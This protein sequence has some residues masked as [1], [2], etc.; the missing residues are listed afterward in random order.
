MLQVVRASK[1]TCTAP[2]LR[3]VPTPHH[4]LPTNSRLAAPAI[5]QELMR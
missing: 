1:Q 3:S 2:D 5:I 4:H